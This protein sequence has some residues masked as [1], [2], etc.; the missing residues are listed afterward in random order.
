MK[1][2]HVFRNSS[3]DSFGGIET[4]ISELILGLQKYGV[5]SEMITISKCGKNY[6]SK[7]NQ[8]NVHNFKETVSIGSSRFSLQAYRK[9]NDIA[10]NCDLIH[11]N[12][13]DPF[14]DLLA[15]KL[16]RKKP[17]IITYH[18]DIVK[19]KILKIIYKKLE[20]SFLENAQV[21]I[22]T[23]P[24][25]IASSANL[26]KFNH[27]TKLIPIGISADTTYDNTAELREKYCNILDKPYLL[28]IGA[29]RHYKGISIIE[30]AFNNSDLKVVLIGINQN[31][32]G[33]TGCSY[34]L[35]ENNLIAIGA[36]NENEKRFLLAHCTAIMLPSTNRSEAFGI[37]LLEGLKFA[38]PLI[39]TE[40]N[41]GSSFVNLHCK[42]G[43]IVQPDNAGEL[44][45]AANALIQN[46]RVQKLMGEFAKSRFEQNFQSSIT[47]EKYKKVYFDT[48]KIWAQ[49][50]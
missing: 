34:N 1:I 38:K 49:S 33:S 9:F 21:I 29:N 13:P 8:C 40:L 50:R 22:G 18:S 41:T 7:M 24:Q 32:I 2:L 44:R 39:S 30:E 48:L 27:K 19:Q 42:T 10:K 35:K 15:L 25:Y 47:A 28:F 26:T 36:V 5:A 16:R 4:S 43:Y 11:F 23:S 37:A 45:T 12:Y 3:L 31:E 20:N 46:K 17:Y 6:Q 14:C